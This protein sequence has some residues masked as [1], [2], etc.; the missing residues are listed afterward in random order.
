[1]LGD[2]NIRQFISYNNIGLIF[3]VMGAVIIFVFGISSGLNRD[4]TSGWM[5]EDSNEM[6]KKAIF[7]DWISRGGLFL[8][9]LGFI[10]QLIDS[11]KY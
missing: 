2:L 1:M 7:Y 6:K 3:N 4:G 11:I 8:I 5:L 10:F 9:I